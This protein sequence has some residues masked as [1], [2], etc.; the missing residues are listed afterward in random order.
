MWKLGVVIFSEESNEC[1]RGLMFKPK[2]LDFDL[3]RNRINI[4][5]MEMEILGTA[6]LCYDFEN[7]KETLC[8][9]GISKEGICVWG[10]KR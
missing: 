3:V 10:K 1:V 5:V 6:F 4:D 2:I 9:T 8:F 7:S